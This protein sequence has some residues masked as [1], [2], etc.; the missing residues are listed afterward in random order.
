MSYRLAVD[1]HGHRLSFIDFP[2]VSDHAFDTWENYRD[3]TYMA[4]FEKIGLINISISLGKV[5]LSR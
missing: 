1:A 4:N 3:M 5:Y 2:V